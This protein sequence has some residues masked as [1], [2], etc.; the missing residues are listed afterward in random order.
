MD[1]DETYNLKLPNFIPDDKPDSLPRINQ[2]TMIRVLNGEFSSQFKHTMVIDCRFEYEFKGGHIDGAENFNDKEELARKL[3]EA[4]QAAAAALPDG[5][6]S[7]SSTL[8]VFHCEYSAHR[9]P[10]MAKFI[11]QQDRTINAHRYPNLTFP[12]LYILDGGYSSFFKNHRS[13]CYPQS[14]VEMD[15]RGNERECE[16]GLNRIRIGQ[17]GKLSRAQTYAFGQKGSLFG[18]PQQSSSQPK[19]DSGLAGLAEEWSSPCR[20]GGMGGDMMGSFLA[21]EQTVEWEMKDGEE[22]AGK[23]GITKRTVSY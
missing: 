23:M 17:R 1:V 8:V 22:A 13:R 10:L 18:Q 3:F 12:E 5:V 9:A 6:D 4:Q 15:S 11:R 7:E 14:Y 21:R 2:E 16:K 19:K 20:G